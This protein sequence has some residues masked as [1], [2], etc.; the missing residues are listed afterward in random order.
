M[1]FEAC[2]LVFERQF[3]LFEAL[4]LQHVDGPVLEQARNDV[5][6]IAMRALQLGDLA[7]DFFEKR[8]VHR[9]RGRSNLMP[10]TKASVAAKSRPR[11]D[12]L[13]EF[14]CALYA[15]PGVAKACLALQ[16]ECGADVPLLLAAIWH[17]AT[18][19]GPLAAARAKRW[20]ANARA[21]RKQI[22]GPL[23]QARRALKAH[24]AADL[25]A[26]VKRAELAAEKLQL[27]ALEHDAAARQVRAPH[28][29]LQDAHANARLMLQR[30][31]DS[32]P[33]RKIFSAL[34]EAP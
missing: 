21:W 5:V 23:R 4:D 14:A 26:A 27:E 12:G 34:R 16:D 8:I 30:G 13:W 9:R 2:E 25:Y 22:V 7:A 17:G 18:G 3:A 11:N 10:K 15:E 33:L 32:A 6:Q 24:D 1:A 19:H 20:Q 29:R 31:K 28:A